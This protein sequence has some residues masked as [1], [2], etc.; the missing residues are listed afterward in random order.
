VTIK[1]SRNPNPQ[2]LNWIKT[3]EGNPKPVIDRGFDK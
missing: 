2:L 3:L 1:I